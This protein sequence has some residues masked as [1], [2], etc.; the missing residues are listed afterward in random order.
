MSRQNRLYIDLWLN[1][2]NNSRLRCL[3]DLFKLYVTLNGHEP[4]PLFS[5]LEKTIKKLE[6]EFLSAYIVDKKRIIRHI[7]AFVFALV[8]LFVAVELCGFSLT[9]L[10]F[11]LLVN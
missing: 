5:F 2:C 4:H 9:G 11:C 6:G 1:W 7:S 8:S 10:D 3:L